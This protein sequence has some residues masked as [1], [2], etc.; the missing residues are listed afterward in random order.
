M[1]AVRKSPTNC[2]TS[3]PIASPSIDWNWV[4]L[5]TEPTRVTSRVIARLPRAACVAQ[6][7]RQGAYQHDKPAQIN[8]LLHS[9]ARNVSGVAM[10]ARLSCH[11][12]TG[13][14]RR[15]HRRELRPGGVSARDS[16][17]VMVWSRDRRGAA[18]AAGRSR[19]R[20]TKDDASCSQ[21]Q[22]QVTSQRG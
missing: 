13:A 2:R 17:I 15:L 10:A 3:L 18:R 21:P 19:W 20:P 1:N 14:Y 6:G 22:E 11:Q 5:V 8:K 7:K 16:L 4:R 9:W 12:V